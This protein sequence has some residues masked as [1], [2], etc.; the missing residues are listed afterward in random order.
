MNHKLNGIGVE[1]IR[2]FQ[3]VQIPLMTPWLM[4]QWK[5]DSQSQK[6]KKPPITMLEISTC[7]S[8]RVQR[9]ILGIRWPS[10]TCN[11]YCG[12]LP[13]KRWLTKYTEESAGGVGIQSGNL[14][15]VWLL[16]NPGPKLTWKRSVGLEFCKSRSDWL[17]QD[18]SEWHAFV[19]AL[20]SS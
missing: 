6:Q 7:Y 14:R 15:T 5:I 19:D 8:W 16:W 11:E 4:I 10:V 12:R 9:S 17:V 3:F 13:R 18:R 2:M 20:C 1:R